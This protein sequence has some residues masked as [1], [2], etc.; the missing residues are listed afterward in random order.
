VTA[1]V[2]RTVEVGLDPAAAFELFTEHIG[3]WYVGGPHAWR[4]P[5]RAVG[6]R[7]E[8]RAGGRWIEVWD[9]ESGEGCELG[10]V[11]VWEPASRLVVAYRHPWLPPE[12]LTELEIRFDECPGGTRVVLEP[13][14]FE[15]LPPDAG[16]RFLS[17]RTWS[18]LLSWFTTYAATLPR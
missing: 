6:I 5:S 18:A 9:A 2:R 4:D 1:S 8:P 3:E 12:P 16:A 14:G 11:R 7:F 15:H 17:P 10:I 13:R